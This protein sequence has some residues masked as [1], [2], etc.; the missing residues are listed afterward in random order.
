MKEEAA[1]GEEV[2]KEEARAIPGNKIHAD[3]ADAEPHEQGEGF[4]KSPTRE[5]D[6][7]AIGKYHWYTNR[8]T[9]HTDIKN[10]KNAGKH[11]LP[12]AVTGE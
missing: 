11:A 7:D 8:R 4:R 12:K 6:A 3:T 1:F 9:R 5:S 10:S 2:G